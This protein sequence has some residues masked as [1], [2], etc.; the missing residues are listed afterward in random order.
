M[1]TGRP[2]RVTRTEVV[3][4]R[5]RRLGETDRIVTLLTPGRGKVDAVA[6]GA[7]RPRS[8]LAGHLEPAMH[9]EVLLAHG[10][11][12]DIVTQA[13]TV[14]SFA[15]VRGDLERLSTAMYLVD[16][17]D[18]LTI[19][20]HDVRPIY[21]LLLASLIRLARGDGAHLLTR[22]FE[23]TLL[24][25]TGF[26]PEWHVCVECGR[27]ADAAPVGW[28]ALGGGVVCGNCL[29]RHEEASL[30]D[31]TVLKVLR[32][33]QRGPYEEAARIRLTPELAAALERVMHALVRATAERDLGSQRFVEAVRMA[34]V[35]DRR[36]EEPIQG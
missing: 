20:H 34:A 9:V 14:E 26:R 5:H 2:P 15:G 27:P 11:T 4:L 13:Q 30:L 28:T 17:T 32:A 7:L 18:R 12:L 1:T 33:I 22:S 16:V 24:D 6:K 25:I 31:V 36:T 10:R 19:E 23:M 29:E 21:E 3:V 8:K 35:R